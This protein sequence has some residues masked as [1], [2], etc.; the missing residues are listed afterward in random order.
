MAN[1]FAETMS[2]FAGAADLVLG[3]EQRV[4]AQRESNLAMAGQLQTMEFERQL[5]PLKMKLFEADIAGRNLQNFGSK[6]A[7]YQQLDAVQ[8]RETA[9]GLAGARLHDLY[10]KWSQYRAGVMP[11]NAPAPT[12]SSTPGFGKVTS[13]GYVND[14]TPDRNSS[15]GIGAWVSP[16]E[17]EQI[18]AGAMTPNRLREND[19]AVSPD[20]ERALRAS[21]FKPGDP[22]EVM[23]EDGSTQP[24]RWMDRTASVHKG[25]QVSGRWDF[26]R[27]GKPGLHAKEAARVAGFR[28][29]GGDSIDMP[30]P[31]GAPFD[32]EDIIEPSLFPAEI[33]QGDSAAAE[34]AWQ[35]PPNPDTPPA[36]VGLMRE[37]Q[38]TIQGFGGLQALAARHPQRFEQVVEMMAGL[39]A[40]P[41][42]AEWGARQEA[43]A[44][45]QKQ[46]AEATGMIV[47]AGLPV[48]KFQPVLDAISKG[49]PISPDSLKENIKNQYALQQE[50][51]K[52]QKDRGAQLTTMTGNP[53]AMAGVQVASRMS[54]TQADVFKAGLTEMLQMGNT[55]AAQQV[56]REA[57]ISLAPPAVQSEYAAAGQ[58]LAAVKDAE[59]ALNAFYKTGKETGPW[60]AF[61]VFEWTGDRDIQ[62][63]KT[64]ITLARQAYVKATTGS[65]MGQQELQDFIEMFPTVQK[66]PEQNL[67]QM[68]QL[69]SGLDARTRAAQEAAL[70][71]LAPL[72]DSSNASSLSTAAQPLAFNSAEEARAAIAAGSIKKGQK[73]TVAGKL[74]TGK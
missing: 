51:A 45:Q 10:G 53:L 26:Y 11:N 28:R 46:I 18:K 66:V 42:I 22:L 16:E 72:L 31:G 43:K 61:Q 24:T 34:P 19:L 37:L 15:A 33:G 2:S 3:M 57:A 71:N 41:A 23:F 35:G 64:R 58:M 49:L 7:A 55:Q 44:A 69:R 59:G 62:A 1:L 17:Q 9:D 4:R 74:H 52:Q 68:E 30:V 36:G 21:G 25:K 8:K 67:R 20:V 56:I 40:D 29:P 13:Y 63:L 73:F 14:E 48:E 12:G 5:M 38:L 39:E 54:G 60:E 32:A 70:G 65:A 6:I 47:A 50:E 27:D